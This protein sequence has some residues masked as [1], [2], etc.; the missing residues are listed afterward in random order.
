MKGRGLLA[1]WAGPA[2]TL[3]TPQTVGPGSPGRGLHRL[4][5][6]PGP[7]LWLA[8]QELMGHLVPVDRTALNRGGSLQTLQ[9]IFLASA[10]LASSLLDDLSPGSAM[11]TPSPL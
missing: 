4:L 10:F 6:E 1:F 7:W 5:Q 8:W 9:H 11:V 3:C 2:R